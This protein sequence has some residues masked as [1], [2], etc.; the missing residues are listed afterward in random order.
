MLRLAPLAFPCRAGERGLRERGQVKAAL[1][2][3]RSIQA[4]LDAQAGHLAEVAQISREGDRV[5]AE[6]HAGDAQVWRSDAR[7]LGSP[8]AKNGVAGVGS[9]EQS[10]VA[11]FWPPGC[12]ESARKPPRA[13]RLVDRLQRTRETLDRKATCRTSLILVFSSRLEREWGQATFFDRT[14][15]RWGSEL[16]GMGSFCCRTRSAVNKCRLTLIS[17]FPPA[18]SE[19]RSRGGGTG[20]AAPPAE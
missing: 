8:V 12:A 6:G 9:R 19:S 17:L 10:P 3:T 1:S 20:R 13:A 14:N 2:L 4:V 18:L 16:L 7:P 15:N 11:E 5:E